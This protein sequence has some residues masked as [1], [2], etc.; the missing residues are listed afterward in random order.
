MIGSLDTP[1]DVFVQALRA[2]VS[3]GPDGLQERVSVAALVALGRSDVAAQT[4]A[5]RGVPPFSE[6]ALAVAVAELASGRPSLAEKWVKAWQSAESERSTDE[7]D[8]L[9]GLLMVINA[10]TETSVSRI[11]GRVRSLASGRLPKVADLL[12]DAPLAAFP[13]LRVWAAVTIGNSDALDHLREQERSQTVIAAMELAVSGRPELALFRLGGVGTDPAAVGAWWL[14]A[15]QCGVL[16]RELS[17]IAAAAER[18]TPKLRRALLAESET[19][20]GTGDLDAGAFPTELW[21]ASAVQR[22]EGNAADQATAWR[23]VARAT[24]DDAESNA[25]H[26][27]GFD[28][29]RALLQRGDAPQAGR[30]FAALADTLDDGVERALLLSVGARVCALHPETSGE[31]LALAEQAAALA[32]RSIPVATTLVEAIYQGWGT[33]APEAMDH[34]GRLLASAPQADERADD[35]EHAADA[36]ARASS[37]NEAAR[38]LERATRVAPTATH[39]WLAASR[40]H[41][42]RERWDQAVAALEEAARTEQSV[43]ARAAHYRALGVLYEDELGAVQPALENYMVSFLCWSGSAETLGRLERLYTQLGRSKDLASAYEIAE[44][45]AIREPARSEL[46][47]SEIAARRRAV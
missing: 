39:R 43:E 44:S 12:P 34:L 41:Q 30:A 45:Y 7:G 3:R 20:L 15:V 27:A 5:E 26:G 40:F 47:A 28:R 19:L 17:A 35:I 22:R 4:L 9:G 33:S 42:R 38:L 31:S 1:T 2:A 24:P 11:G 37:P 23:A 46:E 21:A 32:P 29:A 8:A 14:A 25:R 13:T 16:P 18:T 36:V 10:G 6:H